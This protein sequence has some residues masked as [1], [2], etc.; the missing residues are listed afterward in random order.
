M[1]ALKFIMPISETVCTCSSIG[2]FRK[3]EV[4]K[5]TILNAEYVHVLKETIF[6]LDS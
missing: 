4:A 2:L 6:L 3:R 5:L 1:G